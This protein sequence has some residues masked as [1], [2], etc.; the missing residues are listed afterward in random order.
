MTG[1]ENIKNKCHQSGAATTAE[2]FCNG[3][4]GLK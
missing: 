4:Q 2:L 1:E 3:V